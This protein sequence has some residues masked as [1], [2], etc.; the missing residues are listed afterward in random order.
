MSE[1]DLYITL[2]A[3]KKA[4]L[5]GGSCAISS[6]IL[7]P[8][9]V[10]KT[11]MMNQSKS[12]IEGSVRY[13][14]FLNGL[15]SI[16]KTEGVRGWA[17]GLEPSM[18]REM[19]YSSTR[20]GAYEPIK[21]IFLKLNGNGNGNA[22]RNQ[23]NKGD[24][25]ASVKFG[26]ALISGGLGAAVTNPFDLVKTRFQAAFPGQTPLP[27]TNTWQAFKYIIKHEGGIKGLY[28]AW[29]VTCGRAA[30]LT[31]GQLGTYDVVKNNVLIKHTSLRE[32]TDKAL[33]HLLSAMNASIVATTFSNPCDVI[34]S[35]YMS[36]IPDIKGKKQ[37][38][39]LGHCIKI[40]FQ[41][42]GAMGF[43]KGWTAAYWRVGPHTVMSLLLFEKAREIFG[44]ESI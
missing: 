24:I 35:R 38:K 17:R 39:S 36:D 8:V 16:M 29:E 14:G 3:L 21:D 9:D 6:F 15:F 5:A 2:L 32:N 42:D 1:S 23:T 10:T 37:Y 4:F 33:L 12:T 25:S 13:S 28:K 22:M 41:V 19:T 27:Y 31:S 11:R 20:M 26:S 30:L 34:K 18:I 43:F 44:Y 40:T 7:N